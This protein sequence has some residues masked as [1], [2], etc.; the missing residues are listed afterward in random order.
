MRFAKPLAVTVLGATLITVPFAG[1]AFADSGRP[2]APAAV[3]KAE[4]EPAKGSV[5]AG[6]RHETRRVVSL[7]VSVDP[8]RVKQGGSYMVSIVARG[9]AN[10]STAT[11][12]S[13]EGRSYRVVIKG[14]KA[15][16]ALTVPVTA[17]PGEQTVTVT[18]GG[19]TAT[20]EFT[21]I[22]K[23]K[24]KGKGKDKDKG[25]DK[26]KGKGAEPQD[27]K[28]HDEPAPENERDEQ[29]DRPGK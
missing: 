4:P 27:V 24:D 5:D 3:V 9:A 17:R 12:K 22:G 18:V 7:K 28:K 1:G 20:A 11:V 19:E 13:P 23:D 10:G 14:Q 6:D 2:Q 26:G 25:K 15:S 21:V 8:E 16:K 29:H